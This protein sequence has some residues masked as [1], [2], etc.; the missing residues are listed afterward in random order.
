[1]W[2]HAHHPILLLLTYDCNNTLK[3]VNTSVTWP[4]WGRGS[5]LGISRLRMLDLNKGMKCENIFYYFKCPTTLKT[6]LSLY[7]N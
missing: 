7:V 5:F 6:S 1:M 4:F 3:I 2:E